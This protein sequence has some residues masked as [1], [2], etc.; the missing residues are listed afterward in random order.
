MN[1]HMQSPITGIRTSVETVVYNELVAVLIGVDWTTFDFKFKSSQEYGNTKYNDFAIIAYYLKNHFNMVN[2]SKE[3]G[4]S[5]RDHGA[6]C[7]IYRLKRLNADSVFNIGEAMIEAGLLTGKDIQVILNAPFRKHWGRGKDRVNNKVHHG[8][9]YKFYAKWYATS[10]MVEHDCKKR[11]T[12]KRLG[13]KLDVLNYWLNL[14][15]EDIRVSAK[16]D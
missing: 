9:I 13:I 12:A 6:A 8:A 11:P 3:V 4:Y 14:D 10:A 5:K 7:L 2:T 15:V 16:T 1:Q